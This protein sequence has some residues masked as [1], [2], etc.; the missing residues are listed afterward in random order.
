[1]PTNTVIKRK[2]EFSYSLMQDSLLSLYTR[3]GKKYRR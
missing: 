3:S 2:A 1:M